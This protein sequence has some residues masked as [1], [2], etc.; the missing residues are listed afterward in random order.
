MSIR[1]ARPMSFVVLIRRDW[2]RSRMES[3]MTDLSIHHLLEVLED[4]KE[5]ESR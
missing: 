2:V 1:A 3:L 5:D 4:R